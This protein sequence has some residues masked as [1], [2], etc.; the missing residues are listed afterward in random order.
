MNTPKERPSRTVFLIKRGDKPTW[1]NAPYHAAI[2]CDDR[3]VAQWQAGGTRGGATVWEHA[4]SND[5][6][7]WL[8]VKWRGL[9][10]D[11]GH[12]I[13]SSEL[14][15]GSKSGFYHRPFP[16]DLLKGCVWWSTRPLPKW[17]AERGV[18]LVPDRFSLDEIMRNE[19]SM[20][21]DLDPYSR[22]GLTRKVMDRHEAMSHPLLEQR[23]AKA[24]AAP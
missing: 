5:G 11:Y 15:D 6:S 23:D 24:E 7:G 18:S 16:D 9:D 13:T 1:H 21:Q 4:N 19:F 2:M 8:I 10:I 17:L 3:H 22:K 14:P 12:N 20:S